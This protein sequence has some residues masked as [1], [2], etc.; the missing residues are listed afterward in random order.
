MGNNISLGHTNATVPFYVSSSI[1][2]LAVFRNEASGV[3]LTISP[4]NPSLS[5]GISLMAGGGD[6]LTLGA[7]QRQL[8]MVINRDSGYVGVGTS[9]STPEATLHV[10]GTARLT[11]WT[12]I[13]ANI[14]ATTPLDVYGTVS[15][16]VVAAGTISASGIVR[17]KRHSSEPA[18]CDATQNGSLA[19]TSAPRMCICDGTSWKDVGSNYGACTW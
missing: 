11:S 18:P 8:D 12:T 7:N 16:T 13:A 19:L 15:A 2:R 10:S 3:D 4:T 6:H 5:A 1:G 14:T 9:A 17:L